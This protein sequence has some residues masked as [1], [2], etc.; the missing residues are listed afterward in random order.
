MPEELRIVIA[1]DHPIFRSG[2]RQILSAQ[3]GL[4]I[5]EE[6]SDGEQAL[7][8]IQRSTPDIAILDIDMPKKNGFDVVAALRSSGMDIPVIFLTMYNDREMLDKAMELGAR[9]YVLKESAVREI[10]EAVRLVANGKHYV[11]PAL[12]TYLLDRQTRSA[13]LRKDYP[14]IDA[15]TPAERKVLGLIAQGLTSKEIGAMLNVSVRTIDTHR[16]NISS[17]LGLHGTHQLV[18]FAI[19]HKSNL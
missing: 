15:L 18:K 17:K 19:Q 7:I 12:S 9:G 11:S 5:V 3:A 14:G 13:S 10:V 4:R 2:L 8:A 6:I 1:D 16:L